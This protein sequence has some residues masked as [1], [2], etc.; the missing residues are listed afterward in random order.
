M[1]FEG[2]WEELHLRRDLIVTGGFIFCLDLR[3]R[4]V[5][6]IILN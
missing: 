5:T 1:G 3:Y 2:A 6:G 4:L